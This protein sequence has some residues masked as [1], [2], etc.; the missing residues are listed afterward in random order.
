MYLIIYLSIHLSTLFF[1][2][3]SLLYILNPFENFLIRSCFLHFTF[4]IKLNIFFSIL[5]FSIGNFCF[6]YNIL[7]CFNVEKMHVKQVALLWSMIKKN[8][9]D[10][11]VSWPVFKL[12]IWCLDLKYIEN[13]CFIIYRYLYFTKVFRNLMCHIT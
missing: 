8:K 10:F 12:Q 13:C 3:N 9:A 2:K 4:F 6:T 5:L 11:R 1:N 7:R